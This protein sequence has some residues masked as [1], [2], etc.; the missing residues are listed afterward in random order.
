MPYD[1]LPM[2]GIY[3]DTENRCGTIDETVDTG[4]ELID[5]EETSYKYKFYN[6][7]IFKLNKN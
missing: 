2:R 6:E 3:A 7:S 5:E 1:R 4:P